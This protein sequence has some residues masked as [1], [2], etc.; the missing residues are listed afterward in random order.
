ML[1]SSASALPRRTQNIQPETA[2]WF[3]AW[4]NTVTGGIAGVCVCRQTGLSCM[5]VS[6][7]GIRTRN[8]FS[9]H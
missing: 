7:N 5:N 4:W 3:Y 2:R 6:M 8:L 1:V 9:G